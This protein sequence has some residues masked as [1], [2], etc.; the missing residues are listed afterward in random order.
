MT[1]FASAAMAASL[2]RARARTHQ[3]LG[4]GSWRARTS[5][6]TPRQLPCCASEKRKMD[7]AK[8]LATSG[9]QPCCCRDLPDF[10]HC[11]CAVTCMRFY[12]VYLLPR[13]TAAV[14][15]CSLYAINCGW[16]GLAITCCHC[17]TGEGVE[18]WR[19][20]WRSLGAGYLRQTLADGT[21]RRLARTN[22]AVCWSRRPNAEMFIADVCIA[23]LKEGGIITHAGFV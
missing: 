22:R 7:A 16:A 12:L 17:R 15:C 13:H 23:P 8:F 5:L 4:Q 10:F 9:P 20:F 14:G 2:A 18:M 1:H 11:C 19:V 6:R 21:S 3:S